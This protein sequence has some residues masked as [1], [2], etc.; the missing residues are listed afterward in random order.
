MKRKGISEEKAY[1]NYMSIVV[2]FYVQVY[3]DYWRIG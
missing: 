2:A 1:L 3:F